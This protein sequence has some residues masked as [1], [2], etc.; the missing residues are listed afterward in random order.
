MKTPRL[1]SRAFT[2][3]LIFGLISM[4]ACKKDDDA[5]PKDGVEGSWQVTSIKLDP[6]YIITG[7]PVPVTDFIAALALIGDTCPQNIVFEFNA[8]KSVNVTAPDECKA[9]KEN[10]MNLAGIGANTT[11]KS[12]NDM[13]ILTTGSSTV[14]S[15]L[16]VNASTMTLITQGMLDDGKSH[17]ITV[18]FK[19]I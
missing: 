3:L 14:S 15:D 5:T 13:L 11:W 7:I 9:T 8:N 12:E 4:A 19:R 17:K 10:L 16:A 18:G 2:Y 1:I 6:A